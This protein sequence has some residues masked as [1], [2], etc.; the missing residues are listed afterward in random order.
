MVNTD[1]NSR[2]AVL[3]LKLVEVGKKKSDNIFSI[4]LQVSV[5]PTGTYFFLLS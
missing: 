5:V 3:S 4:V 2:L 1:L